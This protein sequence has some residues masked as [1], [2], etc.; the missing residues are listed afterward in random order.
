MN[1]LN[2]NG[3]RIAPWGTPASILNV[4]DMVLLLIFTWK[5]LLLRKDSIICTRCVGNLFFFNSLNINPLCQTVSNAF[6]M[7]SV[8]RAVDL[9]MLKFS[10]AMFVIR[11]SCITVLCLF[12][13]PNCSGIIIFP[14]SIFFFEST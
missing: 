5:C 1:I 8:S 14:F 7:S 12:L 2:K 9:F 6:S 13:K 10:V 4:F 11:A 3:E